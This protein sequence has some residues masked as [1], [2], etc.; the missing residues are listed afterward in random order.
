M[1]IKIIFLE[2]FGKAFVPKKVT[3]YLRD[4]L[5]KAGI[6]NVP[7]KFF[8]SL[9]YLTAAV[10]GALY[11]LFIY[12]LLFKYSQLVLLLAS[13]VIWFTI[14]LSIATVFILL[15]YFYLDILIY[16]RTK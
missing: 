12:P 15:V 4:Y 1:A 5:L 10:T 13:T 16:K 14:Q 7:Y 11:I 2:E 8:G 3:P 9:F 6:P